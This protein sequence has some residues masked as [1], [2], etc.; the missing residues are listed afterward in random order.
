MKI[1][2]L[3]FYAF[4][5][6]LMTMTFCIFS[7][8]SKRYNLLSKD[9]DNLKASYD[10]NQRLL[11]TANPELQE[12]KQKVSSL[13]DE[14]N[15]EKEKNSSLKKKLKQQKAANKKEEAKSTA[16]LSSTSNYL[17]IK[18]WSDG[19]NYTLSD[20]EQKIYKDSFLSEKIS[21]KRVFVSSTIS[22]ER[23]ENGQTV[24]SAMTSEGLVYSSEY[25]NLSQL[26]ETEY[27][28]SEN[29]V[30]SAE[31]EKYTKIRFWKTEER[32]LGEDSYQKWYSD[33]TLSQEVKDSKY[34]RIV[35]EV[36]NFTAS[37]GV[38]IYCALTQ[39]G[40]IVY[41]HESP[42]LVTINEE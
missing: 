32:Y 36:D 15:T 27:Y 38:Q 33:Y 30:S 22:E 16:A 12:L 5:A 6:L 31:N 20:E 1:N 2:K 23:L 11:Q 39:N 17:K 29:A 13:Q 3:I 9:Y 26:E 4:C 28:L 34:L 19:K 41:M 40:D 37:N 24:Y 42:N 21:S 18:Y 35:S 8:Q 10:E 25:I 7:F 14:L